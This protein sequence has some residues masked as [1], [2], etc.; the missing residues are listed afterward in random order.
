MLDCVD[1]LLAGFGSGLPSVAVTVAVLVSTP[2]SVA[3][4][5]A[6]SVNVAV[7]PTGNV[8]KVLTLPEPLA[9][10]PVAPPAKTAVHVAPLK[11][12]GRTSCTN[13]F[14]AVLGPALLTTNV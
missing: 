4:A 13:A 11:P 12:A 7:L 2:S 6:V 5:V 3:A 14:V 1:V 10:E 9:A 8:T